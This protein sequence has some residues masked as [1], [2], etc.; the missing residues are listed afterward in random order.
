MAFDNMHEQYG[1]MIECPGGDESLHRDKI[2][3][4]FERERGC[5]DVRS[6]KRG[7]FHNEQ[8]IT[9]EFRYATLGIQILTGMIEKAAGEKC[10]IW[11]VVGNESCSIGEKDMK[12]RSILIADTTR[13]E[14][15]A[16]VKQ[17]LDCGGGC[18]NC[19]SCWLG[20][21]SPWD[22]YQDYIDGKKEIREINME[23]ME[24]YRQDRQIR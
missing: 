17:S 13:E 16:V 4:R 18:E 24:K 2:I 6:F 7:G 15:E 3:E 8:G 5:S 14:R 11:A 10:T 12:V 20:G 21:G 23:Y 1:N 19:S 22:I 9:G